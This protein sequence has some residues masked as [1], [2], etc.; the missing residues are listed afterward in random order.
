MPTPYFYLVKDG[1]SA[2]IIAQKFTK[3]PSRWPELVQ[4]NIH[5]YPTKLVALQDGS[6][7][8]TFEDLIVGQRL[9]LP[10]SWLGASDE[11]TKVNAVKNYGYSFDAYRH[12]QNPR[13]WI[14]DM[15]FDYLLVRRI[16]K[17][18][19][20][21]QY[22]PNPYRTGEDARVKLGEPYLYQY[23]YNERVRELWGANKDKELLNTGPSWGQE[24]GFYRLNLQPCD[25]V[26]IPDTWPEET[27]CDNKPYF[28][29]TDNI[30]KYRVPIV[31]ATPES[32]HKICI[33]RKNNRWARFWTAERNT[34]DYTGY[35]ALDMVMNDSYLNACNCNQRVNDQRPFLSGAGD[36]KPASTGSLILDTCIQKTILSV[37]E[38][39][40]VYKSLL[41]KYGSDEAIAKAVIEKCKEYNKEA[42]DK[43]LEAN[44]TTGNK[45]S[46]VPWVP[47][48]GITA[49]LGLVAYA[50]ID[51]K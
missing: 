19:D 41:Q 26:K 10:I 43:Q 31:N 24:A 51:S 36:I 7:T 45:S 5:Y 40:E 50:A 9:Y 14:H 48:L 3:D 32:S 2:S 15:P 18:V 12:I 47:I 33:P 17:C 16:F 44:K 1:D 38:N 35:D 28:D 20:K 29:S 39:P 22:Q 46:N 30:S 6:V 11:R 23:Y 13:D 25:I 37:Q 27:T 21:D 4:A 49:V 34:T 8:S 42:I